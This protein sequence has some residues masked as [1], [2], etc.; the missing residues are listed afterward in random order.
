MNCELLKKNMKQL[1]NLVLGL[2]LLFSLSTAVKAVDQ[3]SYSIKIKINGLTDSVAYLANYYGA[4]Q[5]YKDTAL[6]TDGTFAFEG[7]GS[8]PGGIYLV[9][10][11][12]KKTYFEFIVSDQNF[13][14]TT[15]L[16]KVVD[17][18]KVEGS[19][20]NELFYDYLRFVN[21]QSAKATPLRNELKELSDTDEKEKK[22]KKEA[23]EELR[24]IDKEVNSYKEK[25]M[26]SHPDFFIT[27]VFLAGKDPV[28]PDGP[29]GLDEDALKRW[30]WG[31]FKNH[32]WDNIDL[33]DDRMIRT[34]IYH[35]KLNYYLTKL[36]VQD[37]DSLIPAVSYVCEEVRGQEELFKYSVH[38]ITNKF[39]S[40]KIMCLD[41]VFAYMAKTYYCTYEATWVDSATAD[42]I[43]ERG[44]VLSR[45][46]CREI[47]PNLILQ[48]TA[49]KWLNL[50]KIDAEYTILY[51]WDSSCG[52]C[53][54]KTPVLLEY[55][56]KAKAAGKK[57]EVFA[58]GTEFETEEWI[59][60]I[61]EN[62]L[63]WTNASDNPQYPNGFR[64]FY[65][66]F[67]TPVIYVLD[68]NKTIV[69]KRLDVEQLEE[70]IENLEQE[71]KRKAE[72]KDLH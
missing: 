60:Y 42:R 15:D 32:F 50:H 26:S 3:E 36:V 64:D 53:K 1:L 66:I 44:T 38:Y 63:H 13:S 19:L 34:P 47:A 25:F 58:V 72:N 46:A 54:K 40:S 11:G 30:Q 56:D 17:N 55:F 52:H 33:K 71:K 28:V 8:L 65:D 29:E 27:K 21:E 67:S 7:E 20:E 43:C 14:M 41:K 61:K 24:A 31:W 4:K 51:F 48:D 68:K 2:T 45:L 62:D 37:P 49:G 6:V 9:V 70:F 69:A 59:E 57:I 23:Q 22:R 10:F 12:D 39:E 35:Q 16:H 5:Y 18:M